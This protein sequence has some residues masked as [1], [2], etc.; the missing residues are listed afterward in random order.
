MLCPD[1]ELCF[2]WTKNQFHLLTEPWLDIYI[3]IYIYTHTHTH[4]AD[5]TVRLYKQKEYYI[6]YKERILIDISAEGNVKQHKFMYS[7]MLGDFDSQVLRSFFYFKIYQN[8][9]FDFL[10]NINILLIKKILI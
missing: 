10:F 5:A 3:Y 1:Y 4:N 2:R 8:N 9:I 6:I 7:S